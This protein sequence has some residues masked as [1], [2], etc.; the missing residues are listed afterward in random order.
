M[1]SIDFCVLAAAPIVAVCSLVADGSADSKAHKEIELDPPGLVAR[2]PQEPLVRTVRAHRV[3]P[4]PSVRR[5]RPSGAW[6]SNATDP[7]R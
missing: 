7:R 3:R 1:R 6:I 4:L 5:A 2:G